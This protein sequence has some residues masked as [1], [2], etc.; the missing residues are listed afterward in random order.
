MR[1]KITEPERL[2]EF[3]HSFSSYNSDSKA[4]VLRLVAQLGSVS[5]VASLTGLSE[6][7]IY[8]WMSQWNKK[9]QPD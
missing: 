1:S 6:R 5:Q 3:I 4:I 9:K 8:E 7:T 2:D